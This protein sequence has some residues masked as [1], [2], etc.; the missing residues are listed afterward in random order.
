MKPSPLWSVSWRNDF[1]FSFI[2]TGS[3]DSRAITCQAHWKSSEIL[4]ASG[5]LPVMG[6]LAHQNFEKDWLRHF[7]HTE[8]SKEIQ[9]ASKSFQTHRVSFVLQLKKKK[10]VFITNPGTGFPV[11]RLDF[12]QGM[13]QILPILPGL[14]EISS[15]ITIEATIFDLLAIPC[16]FQQSLLQC[17]CSF[18]WVYPGIKASL[19]SQDGIPLS[20]CSC[21][22]NHVHPAQ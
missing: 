10:K 15:S 3:K 22:W 12:S 14:S 16:L 1:D 18:L 9:K 21:S 11:S 17:P 20:I 7:S 19:S 8:L 2:S 6:P 4:P 13:K 5:A